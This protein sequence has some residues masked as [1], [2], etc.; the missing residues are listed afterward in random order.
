MLGISWAARRSM[1]PGDPEPVSGG[2][3]RPPDQDAKS[4]RFLPGNRAGKG[5]PNLKR[6][7]ELRAAVREA[8]S[9]DELKAVLRELLKLAQGGD[10][11]AGRLLFS[12]VLGRPREQDAGDV[13]SLDLPR[14]ESA[15]NLAAA[16][17]KVLEAVGAGQIDLS[18]ARGIGELLATAAR[19]FELSEV[20]RRL[21]LLEGADE[22]E[23][24]RRYI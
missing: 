24:D 4:G 18:T 7:K 20:E 15:E 8:V 14:I 19:L 2:E 11:N 16:G 21:R 3:K 22:M 17:G 13:I 5:N 23:P 10:I 12:Y 1:K 6:G 9:P